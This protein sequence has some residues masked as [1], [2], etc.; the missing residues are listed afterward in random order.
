MRSGQVAT[1][2]DPRVRLLITEAFRHGKAI[3]A[4]A[5]GV[6]TLGT[7]GISSDAPGVATA[8]DPAA[9]MESLTGMPGRHRARYRW[10]PGCPMPGPARFWRCS[11]AHRTYRTRRVPERPGRHP[12]RTAAAPRAE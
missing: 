9:V 7:T 12:R 8:A 3:G 1:G 5:E 4:R 2:G 11:G 10:R 6:E